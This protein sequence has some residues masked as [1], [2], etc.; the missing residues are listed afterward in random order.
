MSGYCIQL[1]GCVKPYVRMTRRGMW[2]KPQA[3]EYLASR[4]AL[5]WQLRRELID[6]PMLPG[7]TPLSV[8]LVI[9]HGHG[10]H[11]RDLDN[12]V[13]AVLDAMNSIVYPDDRWIDDLQAV[14]MQGDEC[15]VRCFVCVKGEGY[16]RE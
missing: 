16:E 7:Q 8:Q 6:R 15:G 9:T 11:N 13:K 12:E 2:V 3:R 14:R 5:Q 10:F 1:E 4:E